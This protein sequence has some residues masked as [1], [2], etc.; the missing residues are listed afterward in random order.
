MGRRKNKRHDPLA[1]L[2]RKPIP[3]TKCLGGC[4][5]NVYT[6]YCDHCAKSD[7]VQNTIPRPAQR[8]NGEAIY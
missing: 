1:S 4:G 2:R 5:R 7:P 3:Q 8:R 6:A